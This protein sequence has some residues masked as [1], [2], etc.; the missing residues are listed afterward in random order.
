MRW[1]RRWRRKPVSEPQMCVACGS[2]MK[3]GHY[4]N[5]Y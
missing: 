1:W 2:E 3:K 4:C 5:A